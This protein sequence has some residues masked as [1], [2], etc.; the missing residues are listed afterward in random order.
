MWQYTEKVRATQVPIDRSRIDVRGNKPLRTGL[1][2]ETPGETSQMEIF[3]DLSAN[4]SR[5]RRVG[6][7]CS[8][9]T[10]LG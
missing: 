8:G 6:L 10:K 9:S 5:V 3:F 2:L 4:F 7:R 1:G